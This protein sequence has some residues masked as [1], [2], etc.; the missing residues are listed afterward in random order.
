MPTCR[1]CQA[2]YERS[3]RR[4]STKSGQNLCDRCLKKRAP[5]VMADPRQARVVT[6]QVWTF[7]PVRGLE[8]RRLPRAVPS[9]LIDEKL[10]PRWYVGPKRERSPF[11]VVYS[12]E[13][14]G[15]AML[16]QLALE[17]TQRFSAEPWMAR[18]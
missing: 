3:S 11:A 2:R 14:P 5:R 18:A 17:A 15:G 16:R 10:L 1:I 7:S 4:P 13:A 8:Q 6:R 9:I 12:E